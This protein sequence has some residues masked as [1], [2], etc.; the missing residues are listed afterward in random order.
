MDFA[1]SF[2]D[3][4]NL[5]EAIGSGNLGTSRTRKTCESSAHWERRGWSGPDRVPMIFSEMLKGSLEE[6]EVH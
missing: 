1:L 6:M 4:D 3:S 5:P 2:V